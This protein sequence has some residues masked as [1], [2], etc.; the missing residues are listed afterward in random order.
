M[1]APSLDLR[2]CTVTRVVHLASPNC[3]L[4]TG[5]GNV[6]GVITPTDGS[7]G[8]EALVNTT[9]VDLLRRLPG[10]TEAN[11][12]QLITAAG[13]LTGLAAMPVQELEQVMGGA[14]AARKLR[15]WL[16]ATCPRQ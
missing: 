10:V 13:S 3:L 16:D 12:R 11:F 1:T 2:T 4:G 6:A 15:D 8:V 14:L 9:A 7:A 5:S